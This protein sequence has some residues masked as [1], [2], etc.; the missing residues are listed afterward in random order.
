MEVLISRA[1]EDLLRA[2]YPIAL[3]GAGVSTESGIPDFRG[4]SGVWIRDPEAEKRAYHSYERFLADP[5]AFWHESFAGR[6]PGLGDLW[7]VQPNA[8]HRALADLESMGLLRSVITQNI[9]GLHEK[10]GSR[11]VLDYHGNFMKL[12]CVTC[13]AR[14]WREEF[15]LEKLRRENRLPP[16]CPSCR[17]VL[18]SDTV[19][20][21][22]P[23]PADVASESLAEAN[24]CDLVLICG[25][26]AVVYPFA[27][28]P[29]V[30]RERAGVIIIE[31]NAEPTPLTRDG[32]S[33]YLIQGN[34]GE[35]LPAIVARIRQLK[36]MPLRE[37]GD[38]SNRR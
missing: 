28:L 24:R 14:F 37:N 35:I 15:D 19:S 29:S 13:G 23:I 3:T 20:F 21:G 30:A 18:K 34:T 5:K 11:R 32:I 27:S 31:V 12:R 17:G 10:A 38:G 8:G 1:A 7:N 16:L 4:P 26:S 6:G 2:T 33:D 25:T 36:D 9:D 22:E